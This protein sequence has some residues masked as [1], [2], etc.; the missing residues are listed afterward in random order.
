MNPYLAKLK[1]LPGEKIHTSATLKT[2]KTPTPVGFESF[3]GG[4]GSR[5]FPG[6][7][8]DANYNPDLQGVQLPQFLPGEKGVY[9]APSKPS[10]P[11][12]NAPTRLRQP[13]SPLCIQCGRGRDQ[14]GD[15]HA[16]ADPRFGQVWLH[17]PCRSF[18]VRTR[19]PHPS[20]EASFQVRV[21]H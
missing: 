10:K 11:S 3:E 15:L 20:L 14:Y 6:K 1:A 8:A 17:R 9:R 2:L 16:Y 4:Q 7:H 18:W 12:D 19:R 21:R 13:A 5:F